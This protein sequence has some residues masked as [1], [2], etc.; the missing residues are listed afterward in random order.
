MCSGCLQVT[1]KRTEFLHDQVLLTGFACGGLTEV[2]ENLLL[3]SRSACR[4]KT[5]RLRLLQGTRTLRLTN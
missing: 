5:A 1:F 3:D 4:F 2:R